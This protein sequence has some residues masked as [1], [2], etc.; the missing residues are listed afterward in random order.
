M[1]EAVEQR[2]VDVL[3]LGSGV[4]GLTAALVARLEGLSVLVIEHCTVVGGTSARSSGTVWIPDSPPLRRT[5]V[6]D[7]R[8]QAERYLAALA[9]PRAEPLWRRFLEAGPAMIA[10]LE[11]RAGLVFT[12][13]MRA[14]DY[15]QDL[16]GAA[17]GGRSLEPPPFDGRRLGADFGRLAAPI[18]ELMVFGGMMVTR[19]E[20][21]ALLRADRSLSGLALGI[22]LTARY[23]RDRLRHRRGT[24]LVLGNALVATL[25]HAL[26]SRGVPVLTE[27]AAET[28]VLREGRVVGL[29]AG[30]GGLPLRIGAR[31]AV[32]L[33]GGGFPANPDLVAAHLPDPPPRWTPAAPG[34]DGSTLALA[35]AAGAALVPGGPDNALWFPSSVTTRRDGSTAVYPHIVLDRAKPGGFIVDATG[36]RFA[37]EALSYHEFVRAAYAGQAIPAWMVV[38]RRFIARYGLGLIRPRTPFLR[39]YL[40]SGYLRTGRTLSELA[41]AL[42]VPA[43][44][45]EETALR[46]EAFARAGRDADFGR[47]GTIYE[48]ANGDPAAGTPNPCLGPLGP[49]PFF[50]VALWPTPLGTSLGLRADPD[51]RV[52]A[53]DG[54]PIPGL[55]AA[56]N[57]MQ[58]AFSGHYP[59]AGAQLGQAM[60]FGWLAARHAAGRPLPSTIPPARRLQRSE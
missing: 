23:L 37:N 6:A 25:F 56:G 47:G 46:M 44:A 49:G 22:G 21:A 45:L 38:G 35:T 20:A 16:P 50:A 30:A 58:S 7:D 51:A 33:C 28:L 27:I 36:R 11:H 10:D 29:E 8:H 13:F 52:L 5:G 54:A 42:G 26:K 32:I 40:R 3:V 15:R 1:A 57:D 59:G 34:C 18:R 48:R 43:P 39:K 31:R 24:R 53:E 14:P 12:P 19:A 60:T 9:G 17:P 41:E 2:E 55:Y 4:A